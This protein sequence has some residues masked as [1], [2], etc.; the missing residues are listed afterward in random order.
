MLF[1]HFENLNLVDAQFLNVEQKQRE[2]QT[3]RTWL[4]GRGGRERTE[5]KG[6]RSLKETEV[7]KNICNLNIS[8]RCPFSQKRSFTKDLVNVISTKSPKDVAQFN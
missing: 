1:G 2:E 8:G 7:R 3:E 4:W 5:M 6:G